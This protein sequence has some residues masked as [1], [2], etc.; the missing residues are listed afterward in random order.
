MKQSIGIAAAAVFLCFAALCL[1]SCSL[2]CAHTH[3]RTE[4]TATCTKAGELIYTCEHCG[5]SWR[6]PSEALGHAW[7]SWQSDGA[8]GH[9][10]VCAND[11]THV[12]HG[13]CECE[14]VYAQEA[15]CE[16]GGVYAEQCRVCGEVYVTE[17]PAQGHAWGEWRSEGGTH[18]RTCA[19]DEAHTQR[20]ACTYGEERIVRAATC[21][22]DGLAVCACTVCGGERERILP[23]TGHAYACT[24]TPATC[25]QDGQE[26]YVCTEC[27]DSYTVSLPATG[28]TYECAVTPATCTQDGREEYVCAECGDSY[29]VSLP[30]TGH[31]YECAVTPATCTEAGGEVYTCSLCGDSHAKTYAALGHSYVADEESSVSAGCTQAG[32]RV[33]LC[34][35]CGAEH[36]ET[37][38]ALG[39]DLQGNVCE[40]FACTRC[41]VRTD[42]AGHDYSQDYA[43][44]GRC[45]EA[46][47]EAE[48][49]KEAAYSVLGGDY[50]LHSDAWR[51]AD[52]KLYTSLEA[53]A[54]GGVL[55]FA[56]DGACGDGKAVYL[57]DCDALLRIPYAQFGSQ[58]LSFT[59][60]S[61]RRDGEGWLF[62]FTC[63]EAELKVYMSAE[64]TPLS[65]ELFSVYGSARIAYAAEEIELPASLTGPFSELF[66]F[67]GE[68]VSVAGKE[69][70]REG[71]ELVFRANGNSAAVDE[72]RISA[73]R[74]CAE[75][76]LF[77]F[78]ELGTL[79]YG[80][81]RAAESLHEYV[82]AVDEAELACGEMTD[83]PHRC[84]KCGEEA[85]LPYERPHEENVRYELSEGSFTCDEGLREIAYCTA[86]GKE[87][88]ERRVYGHV[89]QE[90][91]GAFFS[92]CGKTEVH[93]SGC[94][95]GTQT[96]YTEQGGCEFPSEPETEYEEDGVLVR[97]YPCL[98]CETY[99]RERESE[100]LRD[101]D[102]RV[103]VR[104]V[105]EYVA[106]GAVQYSFWKSEVR[107]AAH[108][109]E[110][111]RELTD[112]ENC[113]AG[114]YECERCVHCGAER[115]MSFETGEHA[116]VCEERYVVETPEGEMTVTVRSCACGRYGEYTLSGGCGLAETEEGFACA[117]HGFVL[118]ER[119]YEERDG[120][121]VREWKALE[122]SRN[123][124]SVAVLRIGQ[125]ARTE[126]TIQSQGGAQICTA[127][128]EKVYWEEVTEGEGTYTYTQGYATESERVEERNVYTS[129]MTV[130]LRTERETVRADS[131]E[132]TVT[133]YGEYFL[134]VSERT[135]R[136]DRA[137][138]Y[139]SEI[140][141]ENGLMVQERTKYERADGYVCEIETV[142]EDGL[143]VRREER[144]GYAGALTVTVYEFDASAGEWIPVQTADGAGPL[145]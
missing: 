3:V 33:Y 65:G 51:G 112:A 121:L 14:T 124:E 49:L 5:E 70:V 32:E 102:C 62:L 145:V 106:D 92:K 56:A 118:T 142:Y 24:V 30:A 135:E 143:P 131:R 77:S 16:T 19:N 68:G 109:Y 9:S 119:V 46:N 84:E 72:L 13:A 40:G 129:D 82:L 128:G 133:E 52:G 54:E 22:E 113:A 44:C 87:L 11:E 7:G 134:P 76:W 79:A 10:R 97:I 89:L 122:F 83:A 96:T 4:N 23:A 35:R 57:E 138:K 37:V 48:K 132:I 88:S 93:V 67:V 110:E 117:E 130:L 2:E 36:R 120:C 45:G 80:E 91:E 111:V 141:Y 42:G 8:G 58:S 73:R 41:G 140:L 114:V 105:R 27:G 123:G 25:T 59:E 125:G 126:H 108:E 127:C 55:R 78:G 47:P 101:E 139:V 43:A 20:E 136:E 17:S 69:L 81:G 74:H 99:V 144:S 116:K 53:S 85:T 107:E 39:H 95:C 26:E 104:I 115:G 103:R 12:E 34:A 94:V 75:G 61:G 21:T 71:G 60:F 98:H 63:A 15:D 64:G 38:A 86:C 66:A 28:H 100:E 6:E 90:S 18:V 1:S 29:T 31:A 137:G 50:T